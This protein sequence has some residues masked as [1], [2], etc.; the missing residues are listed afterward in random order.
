[1]KMN[2]LITFTTDPTGLSQDE[3]IIISFRFGHYFNPNENWYSIIRSYLKL[4][5]YEYMC[6]WSI[7][8]LGD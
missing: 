6:I 8:L 7:K 5:D 2:L 4:E 3:K 1:M